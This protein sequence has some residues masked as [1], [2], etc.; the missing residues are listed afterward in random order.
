MQVDCVWKHLFSVLPVFHA[1]TNSIVRMYIVSCTSESKVLIAFD[2]FSLG[3]STKYLMFCMTRFMSL[4]LSSFC[5]FLLDHLLAIALKM[6]TCSERKYLSVLHLFVISDI[7][8][9]LNL[10]TLIAPYHNAIPFGMWSQ[11]AEII[12]A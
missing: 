4:E 5:P 12:E 9:L 11:L 2:I 7:I 6:F 8:T 1:L 10:N 3:L